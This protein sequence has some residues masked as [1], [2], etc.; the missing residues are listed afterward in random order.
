MST[1]ILQPSPQQ[2]P[3]R[4]EFAQTQHFTLAA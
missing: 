3:A 4:N 1:E 2:L